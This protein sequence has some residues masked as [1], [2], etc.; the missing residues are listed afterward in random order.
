MWGAGGGRAARGPP[1]QTAAE[2]GAVS[3]ELGMLIGTHMGEN[4]SGHD[5]H[6]EKT[7]GRK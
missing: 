2:G 5:G 4:Q 6:A 3:T 1:G 7:E